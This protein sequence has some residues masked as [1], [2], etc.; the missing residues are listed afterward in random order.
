LEA[1]GVEIPKRPDGGAVVALEISP[2]FALDS[3]ELA[4]K[5]DRDAKIDGPRYFE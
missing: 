2:L 5:V 1:A 3:E 4:A